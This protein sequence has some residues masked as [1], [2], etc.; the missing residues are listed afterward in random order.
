MKKTTLI[1]FIALLWSLPLQADDTTTVIFQFNTVTDAVAVTSG[2]GQFI[3]PTPP[4][5][6]LFLEPAIQSGFA[7]L[8]KVRDTSG[9]VVGFATELAEIFLDPITGITTQ[10]AWTVLVPGK[11]SLFLAQG[12]DANAGFALIAAMLNDGV[13][14]R[15]FDPPVQLIT[16][17]PG[18]GKVIGGTGDFKGAEGTFFEE[19][20]VNFISLIQGV[21]DIDELLVITLEDDDDDD[22]DDD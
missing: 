19:D 21:L 14:E 1:L 4:G 22:D 13:F 17:I 10:T 5:I 3:A 6:P 11:G 20:N 16:T 15:S 8:V 9:T 18:T 2:P 12:E 7:A